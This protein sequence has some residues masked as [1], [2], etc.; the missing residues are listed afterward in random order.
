MKDIMPYIPALNS[1][2]NA[3]RPKD[4]IYPKPEILNPNREQC[5]AAIKKLDYCRTSAVGKD[6]QQNIL[7]NLITVSRCGDLRMAG[8]ILGVKDEYENV[9]KSGAPYGLADLKNLFGGVKEKLCFRNSIIIVP[10]S[11]H[12]RM[13][14]IPSSQSYRKKSMPHR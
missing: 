10:N 3:I 1:Q 13:P 4:M 6:C 7:S 9:M 12:M 2:K 8:G 14:V 5:R 11:C